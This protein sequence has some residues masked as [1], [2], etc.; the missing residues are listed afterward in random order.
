MSGQR[1]KER[2][3]VQVPPSFAVPPF[4]PGAYPLPREEPPPAPAPAPDPPRQGRRRRRRED[5]FWS[6][7]LTAVSVASLLTVVGL[8]VLP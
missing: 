7:V 4:H 2:R 5:A 3:I 6:G 8:R 1:P